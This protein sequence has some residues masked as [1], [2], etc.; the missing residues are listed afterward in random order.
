[1]SGC[2]ACRVVSMQCAKCGAK[3]R[4]NDCNHCGATKLKL[5]RC[6]RCKKVK[7]C[8]YVCHGAA[9]PVHKDSCQVAAPATAAPAAA[10]PA[11]AA[12]ATAASDLLKGARSKC[13]GKANN[14]T[15]DLRAPLITI[16]STPPKMEKCARGDCD[17]KTLFMNM[18]LCSCCGN[19][20]CSTSCR[21]AD[22]SHNCE[23]C[24]YLNKLRKIIWGLETGQDSVVQHCD[25]DC[26]TARPDPLLDTLGLYPIKLRSPC[27]HAVMPQNH[28]A[29]ATLSTTQSIFEAAKE[30]RQ[31]KQQADYKLLGDFMVELEAC[32]SVSDAGRVQT[33]IPTESVFLE[34]IWQACRILCTLIDEP[35]FDAPQQVKVLLLYADSLIQYFRDRPD[36][37]RGEIPFD[38]I[39]L[40]F[41]SLHVLFQ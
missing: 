22:T 30:V 38:D 34:K 3:E 26:E 36:E 39:C 31:M 10:A 5:L 18:A 33:M 27:M 20:Y 8:G 17:V 24:L 21:D 40:A 28:A 13:D 32:Q 41:E 16:A 7:Y 11:A 23:A 9:W 14:E 1:M 29:A 19:R 12:P 25:R 35:K 15:R 2:D 6:G 4:L 37:I